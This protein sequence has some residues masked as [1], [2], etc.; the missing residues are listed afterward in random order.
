[1]KS[2]K[3]R[4]IA[5]ALAAIMLVTACPVMGASAAGK[6]PGVGGWSSY[7]ENLE[8]GEVTWYM[9]DGSVIVQAGDGSIISS[10]QPSIPVSSTPA[11]SVPEAPKPAN[12]APATDTTGMTAEQKAAVEAGLTLGDWNHEYEQKVFD[13]VNA[14][15]EKLG[16]PKFV[17]S[18]TLTEKA[19]IRAKELSEKFSHTRPNGEIGGWEN[20]ASGSPLPVLFG[21]GP[22]GTRVGTWNGTP[23]GVVTSWMNSEGH[24][25]NMMDYEVD[26]AGNVIGATSMA[27]GCY[28]AED[29]RIWWVQCFSASDTDFITPT[30]TSPLLEAERAAAA[31]APLTAK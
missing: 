17:W 5:A 10:T 27:V 15:R 23:E 29:G 1:M 9:K 8:T 21:G 25:H 28:V 11:P 24:Y 31:A 22:S 13:L 7:T 14:E 18:T 6:C 19:Q 4:T 16:L 3:L 20:I 2:K 26:D 30:M 12:P